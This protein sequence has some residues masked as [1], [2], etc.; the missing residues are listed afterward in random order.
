MLIR[1][2][3]AI[4]L[5]KVQEGGL[6]EDGGV[7]GGLVVEGVWFVLLWFYGGEEKLCYGDLLVA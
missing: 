5:S 1:V 6:H 7:E 4:A 3:D 2:S